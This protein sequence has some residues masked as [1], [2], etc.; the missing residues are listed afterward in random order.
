[1]NYN[2]MQAWKRWAGLLGMLG[3]M[4]FGL[5]ASLEFGGC[6]QH[7]DPAT[8]AAAPTHLSF[9]E[10]VMP[11]SRIV[12]LRDGSAY[13]ATA[14]GVYLMRGDEAVKVKQVERFSPATQPS[15]R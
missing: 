6:Q 11:D 12:G 13:I 5:W 10:A 1:M 14:D 9:D 7:D 15:S 3:L 8:T 2:M 4:G